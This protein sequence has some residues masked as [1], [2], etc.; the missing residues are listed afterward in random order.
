MYPLQQTLSTAIYCTF[1]AGRTRPR[2]REPSWAQRTSK[3]L[4]QSRRSEVCVQSIFYPNLQRRVHQ[5]LELL[6][7]RSKLENTKLYPLNRPVK[8][9]QNR[10]RESSTGG[11]ALTALTGQ[12]C[13]MDESVNHSSRIRLRQHYLRLPR[14]HHT[15]TSCHV[16]CCCCAN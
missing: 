8:D 14:V 7:Q 1:G 2:E 5:T 11:Q 15:H 12:I 9:I 6:F 3:I 4:E 10:T 16:R 13:D